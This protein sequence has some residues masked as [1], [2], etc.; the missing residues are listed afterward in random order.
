MPDI[1]GLPALP[2]YDGFAQV[3]VVTEREGRF[4]AI[5]CSGR[6]LGLYNRYLSA[7]GAVL[8]HSRRVRCVCDAY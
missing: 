1:S 6:S 2:V 4:E 3:G 8:E 7:A 5:P